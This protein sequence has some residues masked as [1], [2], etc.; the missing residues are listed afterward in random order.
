MNAIWSIEPNE[1]KAYLLEAGARDESDGRFS[2]GQLHIS[3]TSE[4]D[5]GRGRLKLP[6]TRLIIDGDPSE[7]DTFLRAFRLRFMRGGG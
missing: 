2:L 7:E 3:V 5:S 6:R 4:P 1:I